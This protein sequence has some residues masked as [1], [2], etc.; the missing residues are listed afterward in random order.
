MIMILFAAVAGWA[1]TPVLE[2]GR[3]ITQG[4]FAILY[5]RAIQ[6]KEPEDGFTPESAITFLKELPQPI[7]PTEGWKA[8][9]PLTEGVL[10]GLVKRVGVF[11]S[12]SNPEALVTVAKANLVFRRYEKRFREYAI[13]RLNLDNSTDAMILDEGDV[14]GV[15]PISGFRP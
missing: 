3:V 8:E 9:E 11:L 12:P 6:A 4:E 2:P 15:P 1:Q 14:T 7:V 13:Y 5:A 10:V